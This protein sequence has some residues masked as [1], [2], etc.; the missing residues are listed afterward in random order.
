MCWG[1]N[2][3]SIYQEKALVEAFSVIVKTDGSFAALDNTWP[4]CAGP[5]PGPVHA[6]QVRQ[7]RLPRQQRRRPVPLRR[8]GHEPEG[9]E[10]RGGDQPDGDLADVQVSCRGM[11]QI[12]QSHD[13]REAHRQHM[14]DHGGVIVNIIA[15][16]F[17]GFPMM[18]HTGILA[19]NSA[20][21]S[22]FGH[23]MLLL[24]PKMFLRFNIFRGA[25]QARPGR[26]WIT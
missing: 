9:V 13:G 12:I 23:G 1:L 17:R 3:T 11:F 24:C 14:G 22:S 19:R 20:T 4:R 21:R 25:A 5:L 26:V 6:G 15:D 10:R 7:A 2:F 8:R 16:M 18:S